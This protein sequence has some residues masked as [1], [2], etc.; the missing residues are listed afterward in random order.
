[1]PSERRL[2]VLRLL[3]VGGFAGLAFLSLALL[4]PDAGTTPVGVDPSSTA[5]AGELGPLDDLRPTFTRPAPDFRLAKL[6]GGVL[7]LS[8]LK[9]KAVIVNFWAT[10]CGPCK[11]E[12]P[13]FSAAYAKAGGALE[14]VAVNVKESADV[15]RPFRDEWGLAFPVVLD[16][17]GRVAQ[18]YV[19]NGLPVSYFIDANGVVQDLWIGGLDQEKLDKRLRTVGIEP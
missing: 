13:L 11:K 10:W 19:V 6:D 7:R 15:A 2:F 12:M 3:V 14:I 8:E 18:Q 9:G 17:D 4:R 5:L 16:S 1:M